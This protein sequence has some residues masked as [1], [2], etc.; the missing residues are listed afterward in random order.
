MSEHLRVSLQ[1]DNSHREIAMTI[2]ETQVVVINTVAR[3]FGGL[4]LLVGGVFLAG[5]YATEAYSWIDVAVGSLLMAIESRSLW[6]NLS[7]LRPW[8]VQRGA[9]VVPIKDCRVR[10]LQLVGDR[11]GSPGSVAICAHEY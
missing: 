3:L 1:S 6:Q 2:Y 7:R 8:R 11:N 9:W 4:A 5:A 10:L